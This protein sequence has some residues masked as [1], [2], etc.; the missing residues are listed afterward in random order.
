LKIVPE[1]VWPYNIKKI[2]QRKYKKKL[3]F[4]QKTFENLDFCKKN[5]GKPIFLKCLTIKCKKTTKTSKEPPKKQKEPQKNTQ[6]C[7]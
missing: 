7:P 3:D 6:K 2:P 5:F 1:N 4:D